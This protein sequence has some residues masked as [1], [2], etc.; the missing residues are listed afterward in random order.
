MSTRTRT[1]FF[2]LSVCM[3]ALTACEAQAPV[4]V[5]PV[6]GKPT[7]VA[8]TPPTEAPAKPR[9]TPPPPGA[10]MDVHLPAATWAEQP[11]GLTV[12]MLPIA[13]LPL[14]E[15]RVV[16]MGGRAAEGEQ[17]G[18]SEILAEIVKRSAASVESLGGR[19]DVQAGDDS[20]TLRLGVPAEEL[21]AALE[22][23]GK[24]MSAPRFEAKDVETIRKRLAGEASDLLREDGD[25]AASRMMR[26]ALFSGPAGLHPYGRAGAAAEELEKLGVTDVKAFHQRTFTPANTL[27]LVAGAIDVAAMGKSTV[28]AKAFA[29]YRGS[30]A[31]ATVPAVVAPSARRLVLVH[32][33]KAERSQV[34]VGFLGPRATEPEFAAF[35][36][37]DRLLGTKGTGR[38]FTDVREARSL[39]YDT[40]TFKTEF[41]GGPQ[42]FFAYADT[43]TAKTGQTVAAVLEN[44]GKIG[45]ETPSEDEIA[46]ARQATR[47]ALSAKLRTM[48]DIADAVTDQKRMGLPAA[49]TDQ[50]QR[51]IAATTPSSVRAAAAQFLAAGRAIVVVAG[52]ADQIGTV[53]AE[54]GAVEVVDAA[55]GFLTVRKI[56]AKGKP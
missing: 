17:K 3:A 55:K 42:E 23:V 53:L 36:V 37:L 56:E 14:A 13:G 51:A 11:D 18:A 4:I 15:V 31:R 29:G 28:L 43:Q 1:T 45:N 6:A 39:A 46:V 26:R 34:L 8:T 24:A 10:P 16:V 41:A 2:T 47:A 32:I 25:E 21:S 22:A 48:A 27:V 35:A 20:I 54:F 38:L 49:F 30:A 9:E 7:P 19:L 12:G 33:P 5:P 52:D 44:L 40:R 50:H